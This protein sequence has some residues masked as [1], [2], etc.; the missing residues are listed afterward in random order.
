MAEN[1]E[2]RFSVG[3]FNV[4]M[5]KNFDMI[6]DVAVEGEITQLSI[7]VKG[8]ANL[9]VK[10][11]KEAA[12]LN[13]S[14]YA[15]RI[16]GIKLV[17]DGM[18]VVAWGKP[19]IYSPIG[20]FSLQIYKILPLGEGALKEAYEKLK[21][22]L[23][24]EGLF[25]VSRKRP[26]PQYIRSIALLTGKDS[27]AQSDFL[28]ILKE[29]NAG[30]EIDFFPVQVQGRYAEQE[31]IS[32]LKD[33]EYKKYD[34]ICLVRGGGSL[35]DLI[36]FNSENLARTL[37]SLPIPV[38]VG[39]GHEKDESIVD[40]VADIRASTPS[41]AAYYIVTNNE[42]FI[43]GL[44][45]ILEKIGLILTE[46]I[47]SKVYAADQSLLIINQK[48][49]YFVRRIKDNLD[50]SLSKLQRLPRELSNATIKIESIERLIHSLNPKNV[51]K[52]G[53][54]LIK[55]HNGKVIKSVEAVNIN[56]KIKLL[57]SDGELNAN[58]LSKL[59]SKT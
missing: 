28:K 44:D 31:I 39:V 29:N 43:N 42:N 57:L 26:L 12:L 24:K 5:N 50:F 14:G 16:E 34:C 32:T 25:E 1:Q 17:S 3:E 40:F 37:F 22:Q 35:E 59:K 33:L 49:L 2:L 9:V 51:L 15:P 4:F 7:S 11:S 23:E 6:G 53:Y 36:T 58:I 56:D 52:R 45:L 18:K 8:G 30:V 48:L 41:Q 10:D 54:S 27:A 55:F 38:I 21:I 19:N 46:S 47:S 20:K 13:L